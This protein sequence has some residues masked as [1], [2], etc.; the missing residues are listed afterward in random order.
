MASTFSQDFFSRNTFWKPLLLLSLLLYLILLPIPFSNTQLFFIR[1]ASLHEFLNT[2]N[3]AVRPTNLTHIAFGIIGSV[4]TWPHRR[5]YLQAWWRPN[6]TRGYVYLDRTPTPNLLPWPQTAPPYRVAN[7][8]TARPGVLPRMMHGI[9]ELLREENDDVRW[10]VM[11]DDDSIFLVDNLVD[12]LAEYDYRKYYYIGYRSDT[13]LSNY[14]FSF[15]EAFGG[16]GVVLSYALAKAVV[17]DME[18]CLRRYSHLGFADFIAMKC[19]ADIGVNLTPHKGF[20]QF[21]LH[22]DI[23]GYLSAHPKVPVITLHHLDAIFPI[24]PN[25]DRFESTRHLMKAG[26]ADQSRLLQQTICYHRLSN[27]SFSISWGYSAQIYER[28]MPR[29]YLQLPIQTF[30]PWAKGPKPPFL[31]F[32]TRPPLNDPCEAP[33]FFLF[34]SVYRTVSDDQIITTYVRARPRGLPP[35][36]SAGNHSAHTIAHIQVLSP[37]TKRLQIDRCECCDIVRVDDVK[38]DVKFRECKIDEII[39]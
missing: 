36:L 21:D 14:W 37:P 30:K 23:S 26:D 13:V 8:L 5:L 39:A 31:M 19:V 20:H 10:V 4:N 11:G 38:A 1:R 9:L 16:G 25:M 35:C 32:N 33:H 28:I 18:G 6:R 29:S 34:E 7:N 2:P 15:D 12:V 3:D 24:F 17:M 22:A 27:W